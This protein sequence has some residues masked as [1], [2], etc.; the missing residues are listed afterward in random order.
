MAFFDDLTSRITKAGN[1]AVQKTQEAAEVARL[2]SQISNEEKRIHNL[3]TTLGTLYFQKYGT[4]PDSEFESTCKEIIQ[5]QENISMLRNQIL[6]V[7]SQVICPSCGSPVEKGTA[8]CSYCGS[9]IVPATPQNNWNEEVVTIKQ[10]SC[11]AT[12]TPNQKF[13]AK[14]GQKVQ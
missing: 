4:N 7:R 12:L 10:C 13:C 1:T 2:N 14:C 6:E 5:A 3:Y 9:R 11:G 8:F